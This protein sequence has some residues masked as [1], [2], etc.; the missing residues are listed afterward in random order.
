MQTLAENCL[1]FESETFVQII[2]SSLRSASFPKT[3]SLA[4]LLEIGCFREKVIVRL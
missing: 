3:L 2:P 4:T 1:A